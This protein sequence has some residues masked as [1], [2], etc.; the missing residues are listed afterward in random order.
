LLND[1]G[2]T[3]NEYKESIKELVGKFD[4]FTEKQS[5]AITTQQ[6][7]A[8]L[9]K[10][11][12]EIAPDVK[13]EDVVAWFSAHPDVTPGLKSGT[14]MRAIQE[15]QVME[16]EK[17]AEWEKKYL[18]GKEKAAQGAQEKPG[19]GLGSLPPGKTA[20]DMSDVE[21][22]EVAGKILKQISE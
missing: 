18:A 1:L 12:P 15:R 9:D 2:K 13:K 11:L 19:A 17:K 4:D 22:E 6:I 16:N 20:A 14:I 3:K 10:T 7:D 5:V 21:L 8:F